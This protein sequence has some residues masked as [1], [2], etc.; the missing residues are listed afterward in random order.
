MKSAPDRKTLSL[1]L[2]L[3]LFAVWLNKAV[4]ALLS[5]SLHT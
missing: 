1:L 5:I 2:S 4:E 3:L